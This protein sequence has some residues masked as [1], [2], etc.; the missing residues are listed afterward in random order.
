MAL[1]DGAIVAA[2]VAYLSENGH[3]GLSVDRRPD[4]ENRESSDID[5]IAGAFAI[6]HTSVDTIEHQRRDGTW[7]SR[8]V[9]PLED[10]FRNV[11][12]FRLRLIFP[13]E[14]IVKGQDWNAI[15]LALAN[16]VVN[17]A[18]GLVDGTHH[19]RVPAIPFEFRATKD[20]DGRPGLVFVRIDPG[21]TTLSERL[22]A[23][24]SRKAAKL[25]PYKASGKT[26]VLLVD[27]SDIALM[28][29]E[30][31]FEAVQAAFSE[32][33]PEG[34]DQLWYADTSIEPD[35]E[36]WDLTSAL[37]GTRGHSRSV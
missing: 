2:F 23:Q 29:H 33:A 17:E 22:F 32:G 14:G 4:L 16:W 34:V 9:Q 37:S 5:A 1:D 10:R 36:F 30:K 12:P 25:H 21:D 8:V 24:L 27:S 7:F 18:S 11:L 20:S 35:L 15:Q 31:T 3:V 13:Y 19:I 28:S 6:E 26:T